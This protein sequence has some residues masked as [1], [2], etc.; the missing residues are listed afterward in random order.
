[1]HSVFSTLM[2]PFV[3]ITIQVADATLIVIWQN[4]WSHEACQVGRGGSQTTKSDV[5]AMK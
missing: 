4:D 5:L 3:E 2:I 1:M